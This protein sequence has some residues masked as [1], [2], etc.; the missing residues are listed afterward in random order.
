[1]TEF[2]KRPVV[3]DEIIYACA[4]KLIERLGID[5]D[6]Q[7]IVDVYYSCDDG[8][9]LGRELEQS[10]WWSMDFRTVEALDELS[11]DVYRAVDKAEKQWAIDN[12]IKPKLAVG[13]VLKRG[14]IA[15]VYEY[16]GAKYRVKEH[17]CTHESRFLLVNFED[18]EREAGV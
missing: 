12:N 16:G 17:G 9:E 2:A 18:A 5:G 13:T 3:N 14:V 8:Y 7:D 10:K 4:E 11:S 6:P 1:M 15:G